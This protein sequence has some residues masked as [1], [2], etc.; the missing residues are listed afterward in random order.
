MVRIFLGAGTALALTASAAAQI[1]I[2]EMMID[3]PGTDNGQEFIELSSAAP[4]TPLAGLTF[5]A[6]DGD[7][8]NAG[9]IDVALN[10]SPFSTGTNGLFLWRD[11]VTVLAPAPDPLT[12]L[13]IADFNPDIENGSNTYLLVSGFS[14][15]IGNDIDTDN[16]GVIDAALPWTSVVDAVTI[17]ENDGAANVGYAAALGGASFP[18]F[19]AFNPDCFQRFGGALWGFDVTGT[20]PGPYPNDPAESGDSSG[21]PVGGSWTLTPGSAN[22]PEPASIGLLAMGAL[23]TIRRR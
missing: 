12:S 11:S 3:G 15:A 6:L 22:I 10:L 8:G 9:T 23:L 16:D 14:G 19:A 20:N 7:G 1:R 17:L 13:N 18:Q 4:S 5:L 2:N 21:A